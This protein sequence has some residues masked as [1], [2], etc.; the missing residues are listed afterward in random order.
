MADPNVH[1]APRWFFLVLALANG[2]GGI[3]MG[4]RVTDTLAH[5]V[6]RLD[7]LEGFSANLATAALTIANGGPWVSG[8]HDHVSSSTI[9]GMGLRKGAPPSIGRS[10]ARYWRPG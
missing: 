5:K 1:V 7:H 4:L 3:V 9:L 10:P 2:L 8:F 6:T